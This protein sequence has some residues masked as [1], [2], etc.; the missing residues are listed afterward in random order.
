MYLEHAQMFIH[1]RIC[2]LYVHINI[3]C[4]IFCRSRRKKSW[5]IQGSTFHNKEKSI[6]QLITHLVS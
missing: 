5:Y 2:F 4:D 6:Q 3:K 1:V